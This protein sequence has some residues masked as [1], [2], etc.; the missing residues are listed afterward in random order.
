MKVYLAKSN[1]SSVQDIIFLNDLFRKYNI[2]VVEHKG[3]TYSYLPIKKTDYLFL[4]APANNV[5]YR[6]EGTKLHTGKGTGSEVK[7]FRER[8]DMD[9]AYALIPGTTLVYPI[10]HIQHSDAEEWAT[11]FYKLTLADIS[12]KEA[13][14][15]RMFHQISSR[16]T[17]EQKQPESKKNII[18]F[19]DIDFSDL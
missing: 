4:V 7:Y 3:G 5:T 19:K 9:N 18:D 8:V 13:D 14:Y 11:D 1:K 10:I 6:Y 17:T 16:K 2:E 15:K 12:L